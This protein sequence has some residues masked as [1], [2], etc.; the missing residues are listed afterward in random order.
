[1]CSCVDGSIQ[2]TGGRDS[3]SGRVEVCQDG[4]WGTV[5]DEYWDEKD[6]TVVCRQLQLGHPLRSNLSYY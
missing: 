4:E 6:A 1:M 3:S 2:L 5:C